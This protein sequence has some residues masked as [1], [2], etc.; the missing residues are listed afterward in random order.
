MPFVTVNGINSTSSPSY[1]V[2]SR[3]HTFRKSCKRHGVCYSRQDARI[4][5][6]GKSQE[7]SQPEKKKKGGRGGGIGG[8]TDLRSYRLE[9]FVYPA[10]GTIHFIVSLEREKKKR[11]KNEHKRKL[12][13]TPLQTCLQAVFLYDP[14]DGTVI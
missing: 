9:R 5:R 3:S 13:Q 14:R 1:A 11:K 6:S 8:Y 2:L 4:L 10:S 7:T 12:L